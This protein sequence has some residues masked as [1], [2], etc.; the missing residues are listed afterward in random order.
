[1]QHVENGEHLDDLGHRQDPVDAA[2]LEGDPAIGQRRHERREIALDTDENRDITG[3]RTAG[4][5]TDDLVGEPV[6]LIAIGR[7]HRESQ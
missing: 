5:L 4:D 1:M 7:E 6:D 3:R 2:D